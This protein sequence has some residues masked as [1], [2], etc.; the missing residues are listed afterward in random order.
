MDRIVADDRLPERLAVRVMPAEVVDKN[1]EVLGIFT[2]AHTPE[3][4]VPDRPEL[5]LEELDEIE[6][7]CKRWYTT[8]EVLARLRSLG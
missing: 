1:G 4:F 7:N 6:R 2:P 3:G 8:E 5:T